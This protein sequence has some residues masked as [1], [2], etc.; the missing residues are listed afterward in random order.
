MPIYEFQAPCEC[1]EKELW[2]SRVIDGVD[3]TCECGRPALKALSLFSFGGDLEGDGGGGVRVQQLGRTFKNAKALD[4]WCAENNCH[5]ENRNSKTWTSMEDEVRDLCED[6]A[7][8]LGYRDWDHRQAKR[9]EDSRMH[10]A[11]SRAKKIKKYTDEHGS[12][13]K[14]TVDD[15]AVW[16]TP[17]PT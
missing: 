14:A 3:I 17:L 5:V 15:A 11:E 8:E 9:K 7:K 13:G 16:K 10:V 12:D 2:A 6:E 4:A 1:G